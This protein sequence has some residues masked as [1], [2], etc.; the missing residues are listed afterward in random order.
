MYCARCGKTIN[1][2]DPLTWTVLPHKTIP[3]PTCY[4]DRLC[5]TQINKKL[6]PLRDKKLPRINEIANRFAL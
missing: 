6:N 4:D 5:H 1:R 2:G 3:V